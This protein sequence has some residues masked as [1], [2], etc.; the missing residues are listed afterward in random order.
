MRARNAAWPA[1]IWLA[2]LILVSAALRLALGKPHPAP[3]IFGDEM[4]YANLAENFADTGSFAFRN[5]P[6]LHG[7]ALGYPLLI[8]P[9]YAVFDD[10]AHAFAAAKAI[11]SL[12]MSLA[13]IPVFLIAR[14]LVSS[15]LAL[16]A[17]GLSLAIP[18]MLYTGTIMT[19]N[20]FYPAF[21]ACAFAFLAVLERPTL[22]R[23][24]S[25][26]ALVGL[27]F[28]IRAQAAALVPAFVT[29]IVLACLVEARLEGRLRARDLLRRLDAFRVTWVALAGAVV[30]AFGFELVRGRS[31]AD[32][33][34]AYGVLAERHYSLTSVAHWFVLHAA[35]LD[36]YLGILP[37]AALIAVAA[38]ALSR[39]P[40]GRPLRLFGVLALSLSVWMTL[41]VAATA[42]YFATADG[43]GRIEER[44]LF[45]LAPLFLIAL[46]AWID[47]GLPRAW[48]AAGLAAV[49]AGGLPGAIPYITY[50]NL[51]ALS[52]T[53]V[54]IPLW[55]L[56]YFRHVEADSLPGLI[57]VCT[58]A[59]GALFLFWPRRLAL[60][61]AA[62]VLGW[63]IL[64]QVPVERQIND[65][66]HGLLAQGLLAR[67]SW[68]DDAVGG[69]AQVAALWTGN[70][71]PMVVFQN[72][73]FNRSVHPVYAFVS[74]PPLSNPIA[75]T[76]VTVDQETG[77]IEGPDGRSVRTEYALADRSV[78]LA[79]SEVASDPVLHT[80]LYRV[81]GDLRLA[82]QLSGVYPDAWIGAE[83]TYTRWRCRGGSLRVTVASW[84]GLF[85][86]AQTVAVE[87]GNRVVGKVRVPPSGVGRSVSVP[88]SPSQGRCVL[89]LH[90]SQTAVPATVLGVP[91]SRE[92]GVRLNGADY[93]PP[94][95]G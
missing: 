5:S 56:L 68:I 93:E 86:K 66:S 59:A 1:W 27:A 63:L 39:A 55:N 33:L 83:A 4:V 81:G 25:A 84:P 53:L 70:A 75:Q 94:G 58:L 79:G 21:C 80:G 50:A 36:L 20:A 43:V 2:A 72:E 35:E 89:R 71:S 82:G 13:A 30:L 64:L 34:G 29:A 46:V 41:V 10:L 37:F 73:F 54:M 47:R 23:Q 52:D 95:Q 77:T 42:S 38:E 51:G 24:L 16:L 65:T 45:H 87:A 88:L 76:S 61:P 17:A 22:W 48:P 32:V 74:A 92:I 31:P 18:S 60:V 19:E 28:L 15:W 90:V 14:R 62:L 91:D 12:V 26:L 9:A 44:N 8:S 7:Y 57:T 3:W 85:E 40:L 69:K 67:R 78:D 49:L 6:G 11:N